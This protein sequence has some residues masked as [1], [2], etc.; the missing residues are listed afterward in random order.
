M[1]KI[2]ISAVLLISASVSA[3][4]AVTSI[5]NRQTEL[6]IN[7]S[8]SIKKGNE[9]QIYLPAGK[10]FVFVKQKKSGLNAK[11]LGNIADVVGTGASAV[12]IGSGSVTVLQGAT[13]VLRTANA[14]QYGADAL[15]KIQYLPI[16]DNAK[17]IAG[18]KMEFLDWEFTDDG[19]IILAKIEKKKYEIYLQEAVMSGEVKL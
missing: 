6:V 5:E 19:Y 10:D 13:K 12:G 17:K 7:D 2:L 15:D 11:L 8:I 9:I 4:L 14:V 18:K 3:Q 16:S 1:K